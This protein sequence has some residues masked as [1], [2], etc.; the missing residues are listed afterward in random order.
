M[1]ETI[2]CAHIRK[3]GSKIVSS[4]PLFSN[5][6]R[7]QQLVVYIDH[8]QDHIPSTEGLDSENHRKGLFLH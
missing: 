8:A 3:R 5:C 4:F 6:F 1:N 2:R 7:P